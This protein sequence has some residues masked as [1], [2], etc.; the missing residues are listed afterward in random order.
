MNTA[1]T[2][3][4]LPVPPEYVTWRGHQIA[5]YRA[6]VGRPVLLV[7]SINA[8]ASAFEMRGPFAQLQGDSEVHAFDLLGYGNSDRPARRYS[9]EDYIDQIGAQLERIGEPTAVVASSLG[10]AYAVAAADRWPERVRALVLACP[11]GISQLAKP[12][13]PLGWAIYRILRGPVGRQIFRWLTSE[14][15]TRYFLGRQAYHNPASLTPETVASFSTAAQRPGGY[16]APICFLSGLLNC[17]IAA[18]YGR[19]RQPILI[20]WGKQATTTPASK[21]KEFLAANARARLELIDGTGMLVQDERPAEF[22]RLVRDFV[23]Q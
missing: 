18:A 5:T 15:G 11:V 8:A 21:A 16:Y 3:P 13:G 2:L 14:A 10:A 6:G 7:H 12:A 1:S 9:A 23:S 19:L 22:A 20:I 4:L 17:D